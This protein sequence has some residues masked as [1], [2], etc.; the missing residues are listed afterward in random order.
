MIQEKIIWIKVGMILNMFQQLLAFTTL[1]LLKGL[2]IIANIHY[3]TGFF[4]LSQTHILY[5][6]S[7]SSGE[8]VDLIEICTTRNIW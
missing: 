8:W 4:G 6:R 7:T 1:F 3:C 2:V 5:M